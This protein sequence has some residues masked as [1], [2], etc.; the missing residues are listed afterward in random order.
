VVC[1]DARV[2]GLDRVGAG[3]RV[4]TARGVV[5]AGDVVIATNGYTG[6]V[7][8]D[9]KRRVVPVASHIIATEPLPPDLAAS[10]LPTGRSISDTRR[11]LTYFRMSP[12]G[13]RMI[14]GGR[15]RF[16]QVDP[17]VSAP[18]LHRFMCD[19]FP[20]LAGSRVTH[21]WTGNV[22]F[23]LDHLPHVGQMDGLHFAL[24]CNGSGVAMMTWLGHQ[25]A[26]KLMGGANH[27]S[28]FERLP[29]PSHPFYS[30]NPW[31]L[32][33]IG[34]WYRFRDTLDRLLA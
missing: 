3:W 26:R 25:T 31:F 34:A 18:I 21:A 12:D 13:T 17:T 10:L 8:P 24:G 4:A 9:L 14:F 23:T 2:T 7:T 19:R 30:G 1:G 22:A 28:A 6:D 33:A 11:V 32:P 15:A 5:T 27:P 20:Q 16:T 29:L